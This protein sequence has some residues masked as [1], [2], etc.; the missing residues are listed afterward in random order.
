M[1]RR[2][3]LFFIRELAAGG[4]DVLATATAEAGV[5]AVLFEDLHELLDGIFF[6]FGEEGLVDG[7]IFDDID[8]VGGYLAVDF[9]EF[10]G[11]PRRCR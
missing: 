9:Y 6:G 8:E 2:I 1:I 10:P 5:D 11:R 3:C 7:V 4:V